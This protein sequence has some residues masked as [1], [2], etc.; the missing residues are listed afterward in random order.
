MDGAAGA[1]HA[2]LL[3]LGPPGRCSRAHGPGPRAGLHPDR[4]SRASGKGLGSPHWGREGG[5]R[6]PSSPLQGAG[7]DPD[8]HLKGPLSSEPPLSLRGPH[9]PVMVLLK[10][11]RRPH[12]PGPAPKAAPP[13]WRPAGGPAGGHPQSPGTAWLPGPLCPAE[14]CSQVGSVTPAPGPRRRWPL[15]IK[16][17]REGCTCPSRKP[18]KLAGGGRGG[19]G[20]GGPRHCAR[21]PPRTPGKAASAQSWGA[22]RSGWQL[23]LLWGPTPTRIQSTWLPAPRESDRSEGTRPPSPAGCRVLGQRETPASIKGS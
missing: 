20:L 8:S 7:E 10:A 6:P 18:Q 5:G 3:S 1:G 16:A 23:S 4:L 13:P 21:T 11:D 22:S 14:L 15:A 19:V 17:R 9:H 12:S 2:H